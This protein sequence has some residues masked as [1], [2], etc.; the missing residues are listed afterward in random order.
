VVQIKVLPELRK[1]F[2]T[3]SADLDNNSQ[4]STLDKAFFDEL[5]EIPKLKDL[6]LKLD[7]ESNE[8]FGDH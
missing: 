4:W 2:I 6:K 5:S 8:N 1:L 3:L 7:L